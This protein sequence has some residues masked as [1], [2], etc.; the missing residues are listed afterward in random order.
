MKTKYE[1]ECCGKLWDTE[2]ACMT[3]EKATKELRAD[4]KR[5]DVVVF[6]AGCFLDFES[7]EV[8]VEIE[9][10]DRVA[11]Q[12]NPGEALH[13]RFNITDTPVGAYRNPGKPHIFCDD[14]H[15]EVSCVKI[16]RQDDREYD[17]IVAELV[18]TA[19]EHFKKI[20]EGITKFIGDEK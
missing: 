14:Y 18:D 7:G 2:T 20:R 19:K 9:T 3:H 12:R 1:C 6:T 11:Y 15:I 13:H 5:Y 4:I 16:T 10:D 8:W 17:D